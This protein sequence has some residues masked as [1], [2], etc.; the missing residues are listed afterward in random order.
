MNNFWK[1]FFLLTGLLFLLLILFL[2]TRQV[3]KVEESQEI[4]IKAV[5]S[6]TL[7][8]QP[9][10]LIKAPNETF[11]L[12]VRIDT[13]NNR[14]SAAEI[15][16]SFNPNKLRGEEFVKGEFLPVLLVNGDINNTTGHAS[17]IVGSDPTN[18]KQGTGRVAK[19]T[20][21]ALATTGNSPTTVTFTDQTRV[22]AVGETGNVIVNTSP[23]SV[24][25]SNANLT[26]KIKFQGINQQR[27]DKTVRVI[28]KQGDQEKYRFDAI[29]VKSDGNGV[30]DNSSTKIMNITPDTYNV[31]IKG[32]A[33][34][35]K[36]FG[37]VTLNAG[38]NSQDW[39]ATT[40]KTGDAVANNKVDIYD[41]NRVVE[42]FGPKMPAAGS[43]ADFDSDNDVDIFDYNFLVG[44][45]NQTGD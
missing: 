15:H 28:L 12:D 41:Y 23:A 33:H 25:V 10:T 44:N 42:H 29:G 38:E 16:L 18:P 13:G 1:K 39:S 34:L 40:L 2:T 4:R 35:Q 14:V 26:F 8:L 27:P 11:S 7:S 37:N 22:A 20:F 31:F 5:S 3:K 9:P 43:P 32:P 21:T 36:K 19:I 6:T 45:F 17:I 30:Y 24:T